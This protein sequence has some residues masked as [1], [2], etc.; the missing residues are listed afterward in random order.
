MSLWPKHIHIHLYVFVGSSISWFSHVVSGCRPFSK[1]YVLRA[2]DSHVGA[3][4]CWASKQI[5][6]DSAVVLQGKTASQGMTSAGDEDPVSLVDSLYDDLLL[7]ASGIM[8]AIMR[9]M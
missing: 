1:Q 3:A 2:A 7:G 6:E 4:R 8:S 5:A 9:D